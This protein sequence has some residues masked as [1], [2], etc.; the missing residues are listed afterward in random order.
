MACESMKNWEISI[1][2]H[3]SIELNDKNSLSIFD[4]PV[5]YQKKY[6]KVE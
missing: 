3:V 2:K 6:N 4:L 5:S 1:T